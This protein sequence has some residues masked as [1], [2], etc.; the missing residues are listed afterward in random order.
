MKTQF[1]LALFD[2]PLDPEGLSYRPEFI[3]PAEERVLIA[4]I[5][6]LPLTPF[7][8]GQFMGK[9][10]IAS[11]GW[12]YN[13]STQSLEP[14]ELVPAWITPVVRAVEGAGGLPKGDIGH[15]LFTE[16]RPGTGIGWHRDKKHFDLVFGL[17]LGS[18]CSFRFRHK[19]GTKWERFTL[20]AEPRSLY[21][22]SG[23]ARSIWEHSIPP[24]DALRYSVTFRTMAA[25]HAPR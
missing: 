15:V 4:H 5:E 2:R 22:M 23:D 3:T 6:Q 16:Y 18:P 25:L 14:A 19:A 12:H 20:L 21:K 13:F 24:V 7:Q 10:R 9:R 8:F 11:F 1:E 17:S